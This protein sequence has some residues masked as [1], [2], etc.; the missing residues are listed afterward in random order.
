[1]P[2]VQ[3]GKLRALAV[4]TAR[5]ASSL[6]DIPTI[7]ETLP[8]FEATAWQGLA[9]P[10]GLPPEVT[11]KLN[12]AFNRVMAQPAV[13]DKLLAAGLVPVGGTPEQFSRFI[14]SEIVKWTRIAK[15]V[16]ATAD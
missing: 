15:E 8:G 4:A 9:G 16:G 7:A 6:P 5:R 10:V 2:H 12:E 3:T 11:R 1:M 13:R 14:D